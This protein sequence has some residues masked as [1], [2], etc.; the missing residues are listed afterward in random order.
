MAITHV[1]IH[2]IKRVLSFFGLTTAALIGR[3]LLEI[4]IPPFVTG[5][6]P[7]LFEVRVGTLRRD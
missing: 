3:F 7:V 6:S 1:R 4:Q 2:I 5:L